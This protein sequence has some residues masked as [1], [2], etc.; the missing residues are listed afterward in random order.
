MKWWKIAGVIVLIA[1]G[2]WVAKSITTRAPGKEVPDLGRE[3]VSEAQVAETKY[4]SNPPTSGPHLPT[5]VKPGIYDKPQSLGEFIHS[6]EHGYINIAYDCNAGKPKG[7]ESTSSGALSS[8]EES[9]ASGSTASAINDSDACKTLVKNLE[10]VA[11]KKGLKKLLVVPFPGLDT[12]I[13]ITAWRWIDT[14]D[15]FDAKRIEAFI[16]YHRDHGPE[17]TME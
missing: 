7:V 12:P 17:Q 15:A 13:A 10:E 11:R 8:A 3:H 6:L 1:A 2:V 9:T 14:L 16:D 4:N 5:W